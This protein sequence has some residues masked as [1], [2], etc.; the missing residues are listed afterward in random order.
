[1][2]QESCLHILWRY[3][4]LRALTTCDCGLVYQTDLQ[5]HAGKPGQPSEKWIHESLMRSPQP[6]EQP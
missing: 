2:S 3:D 6:K 5:K 1:M 4:P